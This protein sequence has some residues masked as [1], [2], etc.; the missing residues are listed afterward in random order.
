MTNFF[1][2]IFKY[3]A[4]VDKL[5]Q[6]LEL[7][8]SIS[9]DFDD[10]F[11][12]ARVFM[13]KYLAN[14]IELKEDKGKGIQIYIDLLT[15]LQESQFDDYL[16]KLGR[17]LTAI[18]FNRTKNDEDFSIYI[19]ENHTKIISEMLQM[20]IEG[21][22]FSL[23]LLPK[24]LKCQVIQFSFFEKIAVQKFPETVLADMPKILIIRR[25]GHYD[26]LYSS[27]EQ[28][29]DQFAFVNSTYYFNTNPNYQK[30]LYE[31]YLEITIN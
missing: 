17:L 18:M 6:F 9:Y 8:E 28:E 24:I 7:L 15:K 21:G 13:M 11:R 10:E 29:L 23:L 4:P 1:E 3:Y 27:Q 14:S 26:L 19:T 30:S 12:K 31:K 20:G 2:Q 22:E 5:K 16:I 25:S